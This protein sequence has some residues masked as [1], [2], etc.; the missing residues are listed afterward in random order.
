MAVSAT[1]KI[2]LFIYVFIVIL[3]VLACFVHHSAYEK[4]EQA[5]LGLVACYSIKHCIKSF[6]RKTCVM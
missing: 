3:I 1:I 5:V 4:A 6:I 2:L